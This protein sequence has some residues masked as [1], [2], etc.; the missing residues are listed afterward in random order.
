MGTGATARRLAAV[1]A[2]RR[3]L[4]CILRRRFVG[5]PRHRHGQALRAVGMAG[6]LA[7]ACL[8]DRLHASMSGRDGI[9]RP[10]QEQAQDQQGPQQGRPELHRFNLFNTGAPDIWASGYQGSGT[11]GSLLASATLLTTGKGLYSIMVND[12]RGARR[13]ARSSLGVG[14]M[15]IAAR[16]LARCKALLVRSAH[17]RSSAAAPAALRCR[18]ACRRSG[19]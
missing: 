11:A 12:E 1:G 4:R 7:R 16:A 15:P 17:S 13:W 5:G 3:G 14:S 2:L 19:R 18:P 8:T 10:A 9:A 6:H